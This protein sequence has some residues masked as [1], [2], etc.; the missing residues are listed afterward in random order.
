MLKQSGLALDELC[1]EAPNYLP[2][3]S[4]LPLLPSPSRLFVPHCLEDFHRLSEP[5]QRLRVFLCLANP[6]A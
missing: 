6:P 3:S 2:V 1:W 5:A 4:S